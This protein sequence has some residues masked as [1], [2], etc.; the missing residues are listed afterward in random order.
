[1]NR[2]ALFI[3][4]LLLGAAGYSWY[5]KWAEAAEFEAREAEFLKTRGELEAIVSGL[6]AQVDSQRAEM[7]VLNQRLDDTRLSV[8]N[9]RRNTGL[10]AR[11]QRSYPELARTDWGLVDVYD[12]SSRQWSEYLV[13]P[14]W[15]SETFILDHQNA[16]R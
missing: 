3:I 8:G 1:M 10:T 13:V 14:L 5:Q 16:R 6:E 9:L 4:V 7:E 2:L 11:F 12:E 15:M